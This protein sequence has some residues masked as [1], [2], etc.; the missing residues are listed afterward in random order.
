M[1][2]LFKEDEE[3]GLLLKNHRIPSQN[4][5]DTA[6]AIRHMRCLILK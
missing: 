6:Y 1:E 2:K 4:I 5:G 3:S